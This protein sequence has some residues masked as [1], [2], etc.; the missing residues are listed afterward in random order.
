MIVI[1][2]TSAALWPNV[3]LLPA[4]FLDREP[5]LRFVLHQ[6]GLGNRLDPLHYHQLPR[7]RRN[8]FFGNE[9][10]NLAEIDQMRP[11]WHGVPRRFHQFRQPSHLWPDEDCRGPHDDH[12]S[13]FFTQECRVDRLIGRDCA[14]PGRLSAVIRQRRRR[15]ARSSQPRHQ[16]AAHQ[17]GDNR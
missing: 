5:F 16:Q 3:E 6:V 17:H 8:L 15:P 9:H 1:Q 14:G 11:L 12:R 2:Q 13:R 4:G 7:S 10:R